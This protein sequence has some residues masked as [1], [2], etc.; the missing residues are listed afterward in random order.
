MQRT[1]RLDS[2]KFQAATLLS[3]SLEIDKNNTNQ[4][5]TRR[6]AVKNWLSGDLIRRELGLQMRAVFVKAGDDGENDRGS[7]HQPSEKGKVLVGANLMPA[8]TQ[9][10]FIDQGDEKFARGDRE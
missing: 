4:I 6:A 2:A 9:D 10:P 7:E 1:L 3:A 5:S 8:C